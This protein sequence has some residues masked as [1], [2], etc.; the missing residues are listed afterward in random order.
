MSELY[1]TKYVAENM[2]MLR[3]DTLGLSQ[4]AFSEKTNLS[5]DTISNI[6]R[7]RYRPNLETLVSI[8]NATGV[9]VDY[10]LKKPIE[11]G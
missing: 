8:S 5:K 2:Y 3:K 4:E 1:N 6:E 9:S 11:K 7:G 10:F